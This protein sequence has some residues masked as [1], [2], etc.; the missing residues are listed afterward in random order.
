MTK[1]RAELRKIGDASDIRVFPDVFTASKR[2]LSMPYEHQV[3]FQV[4][5]VDE[6]E[7]YEC[8]LFDGGSDDLRDFAGS[9]NS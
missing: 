4:W 9:F 8:H 2:L 1:I 5:D 7:D 3:H 6:T